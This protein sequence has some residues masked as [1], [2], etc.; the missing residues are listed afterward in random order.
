MLTTF[1]G[2]QKK[3]RKRKGCIDGKD[4]TICVSLRR[5]EIET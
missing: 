1:K 4:N 5:R 2:E 3:N